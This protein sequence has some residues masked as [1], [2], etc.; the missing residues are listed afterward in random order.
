MPS[1]APAAPAA[2]PVAADSVTIH[3]FAFG[4]QVVTIKAGTTV[5]WKNGDAEA[6]T[7]TSDSGAFDSPVLQP[8]ASYSH[9]FTKP[10][11]YS[12]HCTIHP[13]MTGKVVVS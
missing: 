5:H 2:A 6:H 11:T 9:T 1:S 7:V 12:Y 10:G 4:P 8:G 3:N 13:F